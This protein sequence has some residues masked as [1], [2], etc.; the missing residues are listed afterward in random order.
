MTTAVAAPEK[1]ALSL[2]VQKFIYAKQVEERS[3]RTLEF[4]RDNLSRFEVWAR[5]KGV[6]ILSQVDRSLI[7]EF[8]AFIPDA[9]WKHSHQAKNQPVTV[10]A[11]FRTLR[12]FFKWCLAEEILPDSAYPLRNIKGPKVE[13]KVIPSVTPDK[14]KE[15]IRGLDSDF[16]G[17]RNKATLL[18]FLDTGLRL[19]ELANIKLSDMDLR[20]GLI[21]VMGKGS[22]ERVVR[23]G[24]VTLE[25]LL[26]YIKTRPAETDFL[27]QNQ[28]GSQFLRRGFQIMIR[29]MG[30]S[31]GINTLSP[32][33]FRHTFALQWLRSGVDVFTLRKHGGW[34]GLPILDRYLDGIQAE[35]AIKAHM[36]ASPVEN[37]MGKPVSKRPEI[38]PPVILPEEPERKPAPVMAEP[39][40]KSKRGRPRRKKMGRPRIKS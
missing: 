37:L 28:D 25:A 18:M 19:S 11:Y 26:K 3:P 29:R 21:K 14:F 35:D 13:R 17:V 1:T 24:G 23:M 10:H 20:A 40:S 22:R 9:P 34:A 16:Q 15:L 31:I 12:A 32:H 8:L 4:Y 7:R 36:R 38:T 30:K 6:K 27:W 39:A 5:A 33:K 2:A